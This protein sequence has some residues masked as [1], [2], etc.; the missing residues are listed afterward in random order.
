MNCFEALNAMSFKWSSWNDATGPKQQAETIE[1]MMRLIK[2]TIFNPIWVG[3][4]KYT[5]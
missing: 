3:P 5:V 4:K 2:P 1:Q